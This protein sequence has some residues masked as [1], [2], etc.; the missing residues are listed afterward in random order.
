MEACYQ[1]NIID[2]VETSEKSEKIKE[3]ILQGFSYAFFFFGICFSFYA[4]LTGNN[5]SQTT[6]A[7]FLSATIFFLFSCKAL[8]KQNFANGIYYTGFLF[9]LG[10]CFLSTALSTKTGLK[11]ETFL[12][13]NY[14]LLGI[15]PFMLFLPLIPKKKEQGEKLD[16]TW[17]KRIAVHE[18]GHALVDK[19][20]HDNFCMMFNITGHYVPDNKTIAETLVIKNH[21]DE[22]KLLLSNTLGCLA[23]HIAEAVM[24]HKS[25][26]IFAGTQDAV[27]WEKHVL[28]FF[29]KNGCQI[30]PD[31]LWDIQSRQAGVLH[32]FFEANK[33]SLQY[34][35][36]EFL[37][38]GYICHSEIHFK[39][40]KR[41]LLLRYCKKILE[42]AR[43]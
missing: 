16:T 29:A 19:V 33:E 4:I 2:L 5:T 37:R 10:I 41:K 43:S 25:V 26:S 17:L 42:E 23:G 6:C 15:L 27:D 7:F 40:R 32:K 36:D 9:I 24:F 20:L 31:A 35:A 12:Q 1:K 22:Q 39:L 18:A 21:A 34:L 14:A 38:T 11:I 13:E 3:R 8:I 30:M 28:R